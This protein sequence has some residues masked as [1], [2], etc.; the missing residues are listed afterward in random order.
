MLLQFHEEQQK[1]RKARLRNG[2][3]AGKRAG[4]VGVG[5]WSGQG[6]AIIR[7]ATQAEGQGLL[8]GIY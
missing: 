4:S 1:N 2:T 5:G 7:Q 6:L 3:Q 8:L